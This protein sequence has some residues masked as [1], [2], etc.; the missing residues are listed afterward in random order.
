M[1]KFI[2]LFIFSAIVFACGKDEIRNVN[3]FLPNYRFAYDIN[4]NLPLYNGLRNNGSPIAINV[5]GVGINGIIVMKISDNN[6]VAWDA[7]CPNMYPGM[8]DRL[9]ITGINAK[10][11]C[12][13]LEYSLYTGVGPGAQY[14]LK[15]YL[16][17]AAGDNV[18]VTN[19]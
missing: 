15:P 1:K 4:T 7:A 10:C 9:E 17:Q 16:V 12:D 19:Q 6:Y 13:D 14:T 8:C 11:P 2:A 18:R 5:E 3:P